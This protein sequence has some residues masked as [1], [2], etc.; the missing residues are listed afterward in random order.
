MTRAGHFEK[1]SLDQFA[2]AMREM[3][4]WLTDDEIRAIYDAI[5]LPS[6]ATA[7]SAGY[8][9]HAPFTFGLCPGQSIKIPTGIRVKVNGG[10]WLG[11]FPR[12][13]LGFKYRLQLDNTVGVIDAD[14][15]YSD[16]EGHIFAKLTNHSDTKTL[17][18][19]QGD[20]FMQG[21]FIPY[22]ITYDDNV[23]ATRNGGFGSTDRKEPTCS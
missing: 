6:R 23:A 13:G 5:V 2:S 1:V 19:N 20:A 22:G 7:G 4:V 11:C 16:N 9:F 17:E 3:S 10:W 18:L 14:Y 12:S 8:D 21:I 15:Y